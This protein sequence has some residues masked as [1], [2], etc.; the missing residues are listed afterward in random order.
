MTQAIEWKKE[1]QRKLLHEIQKIN[2]EN[3]LAKERKKEEEKLADLRALEYTQKKLVRKVL[4]PPIS[5]TYVWLDSTE[6]TAR[7]QH[8]YELL[9]V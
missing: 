7:I 8:I 3:L 6:S 5:F 1:E 9:T 4:S 2:D